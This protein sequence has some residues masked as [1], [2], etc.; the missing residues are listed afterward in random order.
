M[1]SPS[2]DPTSERRL[3]PPRRKQTWI[4][5]SILAQRCGGRGVLRTKP[6]ILCPQLSATASIS[7]TL[8]PRSRVLALLGPFCARGCPFR[9]ASRTVLRDCNAR[10]FL[11][12]AHIFRRHL[13][14]LHQVTEAEAKRAAA[15]DHPPRSI[16]LRLAQMLASARQSQRDTSQHR[17]W[18]H[19]IP[20]LSK[21]R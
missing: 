8:R 10:T 11:Q 2:A 3:L 1:Y 15:V 6:S 7:S 19:T 17:V 13:P 12:C 20:G 4:A 14:L 18:P 5:R 21:I 9:G 16:S